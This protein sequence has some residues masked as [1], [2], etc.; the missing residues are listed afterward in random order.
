MK[1]LKAETL[2]AE[3]RSEY[4]ARRARNRSRAMWGLPQLSGTKGSKTEEPLG[5]AANPTTDQSA[6]VTDRR[7]SGAGKIA[8][9]G[10]QGRP[11]SPGASTTGAPRKGSQ[12]TK[13]EL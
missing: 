8:V 1:K 11:S 12:G 5:C 2:K 7:Y 9:R 13:G 3:S 4:F 10:S 6:T